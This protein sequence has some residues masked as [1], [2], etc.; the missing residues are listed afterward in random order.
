[1]TNSV[2]NSEGELTKGS[3]LP[4]GIGGVLAYCGPGAWP[5]AALL[6]VRDV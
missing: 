2:N 5:P 6:D 4:R 1:M 3:Q